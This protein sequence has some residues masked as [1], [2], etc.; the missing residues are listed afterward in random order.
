MSLIKSI[1]MEL[2]SLFVVDG[3]LALHVLILVLAVAA[4]VE[5]L[6]VAPL[7]GGGLLIVGCLAILAFSLRRKA[8]G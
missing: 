8:R 2:L 5:G 4:L 1:L 3:A 6:G 7:I